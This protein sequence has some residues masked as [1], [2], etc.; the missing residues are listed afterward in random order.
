MCDFKHYYETLIIELSKFTHYYG[1]LIFLVRGPLTL[2]ICV[3]STLDFFVTVYGR[4]QESRLHYMLGCFG[5]SWNDN[6]NNN[7]KMF[8]IAHFLK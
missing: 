6:N 5:C 1:R 7:N 4:S 2:A 8:Y 3:T